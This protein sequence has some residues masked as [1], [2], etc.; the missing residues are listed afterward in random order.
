MKF[1]FII[2]EPSCNIHWQ[3]YAQTCERN[4]YMSQSWQFRV[5]HFFIWLVGF[6]FS[7]DSITH[8]ANFAW[9]TFFCISISHKH[10]LWRRWDLTD[11]SSLSAEWGRPVYRQNSPLAF[12][13]KSHLKNYCIKVS[14]GRDILGSLAFTQI[15][16]NT[17][18]HTHTHTCK[19]ACI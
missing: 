15:H 7:Q 13:W 19:Q 1:N 3:D 2:S 10:I 6:V 9:Y 16:T 14:Y 8:T 11:Q 18:I 5:F 17:Q 4:S 12:Y